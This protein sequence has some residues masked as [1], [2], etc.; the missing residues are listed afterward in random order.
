MFSTKDSKIEEKTH[1]NSPTDFTI[2][3]R[4]ELNSHDK[5]KDWG[6]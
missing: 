2:E 5:Q 4:L 3:M 6:F 1:R